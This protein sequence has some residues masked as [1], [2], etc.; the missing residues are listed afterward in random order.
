MQL[1]EFHENLDFENLRQ[2]DFEVIIDNFQT[3][4]LHFDQ[5]RRRIVDVV[6][7]L[8]RRVSSVWFIRDSES[9]DDFVNQSCF[10]KTRISNENDETI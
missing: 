1:N 3:L 7:A 5:I 2:H 9:N 4:L 8:M 6:R 10:D